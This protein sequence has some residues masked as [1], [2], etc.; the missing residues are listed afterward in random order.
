MAE[1][2][3]NQQNNIDKKNCH[4]VYHKFLIG[5]WIFTNQFCLI[6]KIFHRTL[7]KRTLSNIVI[8]HV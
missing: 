3:L 4:P 8:T 5:R 7:I 6:S 2:F 1:T